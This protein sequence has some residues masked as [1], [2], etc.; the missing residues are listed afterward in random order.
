MTAHAQTARAPGKVNLG[1]WVGQVDPSGY[2]PLLTAFQ[3]VELWET[4]SVEPDSRVTLTCSGSVDCSEVPL[5][6]SNLAWRAALALGEQVGRTVDVAL[7]IEKNVPVAG[8]MAGGSADAAA[9]LLALRSYWQLD[10]DNR[11]LHDL[12]A[13][14]GSDVAF[15][16]QGGAAIGRGR[17]DQLE[18]VGTQQPLHWVVVPA[19]FSLST[20]EVY[21]HYDHIAPRAEIPA[22]LPEGFLEAWATGNARGLAGLMHNDLEAAACSMRPELTTT[23]NAVSEAGALRAMVSGSGPTVMGLAESA[24]H[25][26]DI[27]AALRG[28]GYPALTTQSAEAN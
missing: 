8:G 16:L 7:H 6:A 15:S 27:V 23:V 9:T 24:E 5:D 25:A 1:L 26:R 10:I 21:R 20:A 11:E 3:A 14:L 13:T 28:Q 4:V 17:G 18:R 2:H 12:A 19:D 22:H